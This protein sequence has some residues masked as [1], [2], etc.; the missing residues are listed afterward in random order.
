[1]SDGPGGGTNEPQDRKVGSEHEHAEGHPERVRDFDDRPE[2][3]PAAPP[4]R[5]GEAGDPAEGRV[6]PPLPGIPGAFAAELTIASSY[7]G[8]ILPEQ[9]RAYDDLV[10][11][12][13]EKIIHSQIIQPQDRLDRV[14]EAEIST[15]KTG[16]G[17]AI[18]IC[19]ILVG[20][21]IAFFF[22]GD[23]V[24]GITLVGAPLIASFVGLFV[25]RI[26]R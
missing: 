14:A 1:M 4:D 15:A 16:Q 23:T 6:Q 11:G 9:V 22:R 2:P 20:F 17:W 7:T 13:G 12:I 5:V 8:P 10:P 24:A 3:P 21:G 25:P 19:L 26:R 18:F